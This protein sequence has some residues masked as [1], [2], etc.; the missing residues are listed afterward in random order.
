MKG[1]YAGTFDPPTLGHYWMIRKGM[2]LFEE[3]IVAIAVNPTKTPMF[4]TKERS[5]MI[6]ECIVRAEEIFENG[7]VVRSKASV[8]IIDNQYLIDVASEESVDHILRGIRGVQDFPSEIQYY[9]FNYQKC[10]YINTVFLIPP[11]ELRHIS[12]SFVKMLIGPEGWEDEVKKLVIPSVF[13]H[14]KNKVK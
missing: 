8:K 11:P 4:K 10:S 5:S 7:Y 12:S 2:E 13:D 9:D 3:L 6:E 14:I 1:I